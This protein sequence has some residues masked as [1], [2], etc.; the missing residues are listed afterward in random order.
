MIQKE[1]HDLIC[2]NGKK[3]DEWLAAKKAEL[4]LPFYTSIDIRDSHHKIV[5]VDANIYPAGFNNICPTDK[6]HAPEIT[7][8]YLKA[9]Y[10]DKVKKIA[11][12]TE[13]HTKNAYYWENVKWIL[14]MIE[15]AGYEIRVCLPQVT[16]SEIQVESSSG[17]KITVHPFKKVNG[18]LVGHD[19]FKPDLIIS[20]NDFSNAYEAWAEGLKT[21]I[22]PPR[23][24]GWHQRKKSDHFKYFNQ[25]AT[26]FANIIGIDPWILTVETELVE[27]FDVNDLDSR[28]NVATKVDAMIARIQANYD[29]RGIKDKPTVFVKNNSGTYGLGVMRA[30]SGDDIRMLNS[31]GRGKMNA[32][33]GGGDVS[34]VILQEGVPT[35]VM[36]EGVVAEPV[37]YI[38]GCDLAGG[39]FRTH[40]EKGPDDSLNSPG[41]VYKK[42]CVSDLKVDQGGCPIENV[43]GWIAK[44]SSLA[45]GYEMQRLNLKIA[46]NPD[47]KNCKK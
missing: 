11:L 36:A 17:S 39:F 42:M 3:V 30:L 46:M 7:R 9:Y 29:K 10:G 26:E 40:S 41:A 25:L 45:I 27:E 20:N 22:N 23:E 33:K 1:I 38:V 34:E 32:A 14:K 21:P 35:A 43:Y 37:V 31:K 19:G 47:F 6:E 13:E 5:S 44:L 16:D 28:D 18:E 4:Q 12:L 24:L 15:D 2:K 8:D